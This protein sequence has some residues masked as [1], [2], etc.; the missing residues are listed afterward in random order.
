MSNLHKYLILVA[1]FLTGCN[2]T[3]MPHYDGQNPSAY[4]KENCL[5]KPE[6][7]QNSEPCQKAR[8]DITM[9]ALK[10]PPMQKW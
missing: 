9:R 7:I 6:N 5:N 4:N 10:T 8:H 1:I 3:S 2:E